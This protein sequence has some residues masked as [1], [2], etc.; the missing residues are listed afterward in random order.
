MHNNNLQYQFQNKNKT[1]PSSL[2]SN[3]T[4]I[5]PPLPTTHV[6]TKADRVTSRVKKKKNTGAANSLSVIYKQK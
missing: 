5:A 2:H 6:A 1:Q 3:Q 4:S